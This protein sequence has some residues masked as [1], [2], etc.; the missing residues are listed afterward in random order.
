[1]PVNLQEALI[2]ALSHDVKEPLRTSTS[3]TQLLASKL[4]DK[5]QIEYAEIISKE[6]KRLDNLLQNIRQVFTP[7]AMQVRKQSVSLRR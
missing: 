2:S 5:E 3:Y 6:L 1:L 4:E 7:S